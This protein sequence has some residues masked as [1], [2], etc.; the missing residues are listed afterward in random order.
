M[1]LVLVRAI[2]CHQAGLPQEN[3]AFIA[4][5]QQILG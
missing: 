1:P 4:A 3:M 5:L 2:A